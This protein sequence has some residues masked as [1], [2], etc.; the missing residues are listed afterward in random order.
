MEHKLW[1]DGQWQ[2]TQG[3][4]MMKIEDP[5]TGKIIAEVIDASRA[6]WVDAWDQVTL[7]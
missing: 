3:G 6:D 4:S 7:R 5:T 1:I 2:D